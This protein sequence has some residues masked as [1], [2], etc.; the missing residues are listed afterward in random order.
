M[1][2]NLDWSDYAVVLHIADAGS[3]SKAAGRAGVSHPTLFRRI[4]AVEERLGVRLFE[5][6]RSGYV[7]TAAGEE[8][9]ATARRVADLTNEVERRVAGRDLRPSGTV[10]LST[11]DTL[12]VG[13]L[14]PEIARFRRAQ[15]DIVLDITASNAVSDLSR[16]E[17]DVALRPAAAPEDHL[18]G[19][20]LG[21][22]H[23][24][25]Y[26]HRATAP[27]AAV[28]RRGLPWVGP[29]DAMGYGQLT[30]WFRQA[31]LDEACVARM[32]SV[33]GIHA[34]IRAG[35]GVGILPCYLGGPDPEL[36]QVG[37]PI[38]ALSVDLWMLTHPDLRGTARIRAVL[39]HFGQARLL[40]GASP[41]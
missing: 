23:Q 32:S 30:T 26:A 28:D 24:A 4:N 15:P 19:R 25:V 6:L 18:F 16:R 14:A 2:N 31:G 1:N 41:S 3:L 33:L 12:L 36:V 7:P 40:A 35:V 29:G 37:A 17:A 8:V 11:T 9:V 34:A 20:K 39:D 27:A 22:V 13:P 21:M 5:R 10:R 38:D